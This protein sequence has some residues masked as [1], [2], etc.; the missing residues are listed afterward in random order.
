MLLIVTG[1]GSQSLDAIEYNDKP[2]L[3]TLA[4]RCEKRC[5]AGQSACRAFVQLIPLLRKFEANHFA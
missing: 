5:S 2:A 4:V 3:M 1:W